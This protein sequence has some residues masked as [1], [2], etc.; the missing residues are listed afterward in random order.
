MVSAIIG[1][2]FESSLDLGL[3]QAEFSSEKIK[4]Y[5]GPTYLTVNIPRK[6]DSEVGAGFKHRHVH[7]RDADITGGLLMPQ[8]AISTTNI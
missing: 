6:L 4:L 3:S 5:P 8:S 2:H 1:E 7:I